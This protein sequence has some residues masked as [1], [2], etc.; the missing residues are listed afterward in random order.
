MDFRWQRLGKVR[1][2]KKAI[3]EI[4]C[5]E[6][7]HL[8]F[9]PFLREIGNFTQKPYWQKHLIDKDTIWQLRH[10]AIYRT[11]RLKPNTTSSFR[12]A[13]HHAQHPYP[14]CPPPSENRPLPTK[15]IS[16]YERT[17]HWVFTWWLG[18]HRGCIG[19]DAPGFPKIS[20][21]AQFFREKKIILETNPVTVYFYLSTLSLLKYFIL[22]LLLFRYTAPNVCIIKFPKGCQLALQYFTC[23]SDVKSRSKY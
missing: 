3:T 4:S 9:P 23:G 22:I 20:K 8:E 2:Y 18:F 1:I 21:N 11:F 5:W 17:P 7:V 19:R 15:Q 16:Q 10:V 13:T 6:I 14:F 12:K